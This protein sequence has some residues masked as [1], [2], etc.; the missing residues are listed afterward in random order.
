MRK[1]V[2][3][4]LALAAWT[5][6]VQAQQNTRAQIMADIEKTGGVHYM[7][8]MDQ[9]VPT[10]A[11]KGYQPFY[12]SHVGRHGA[13]FALGGKVYEE[14]LEVWT[15]AH[16]K[17]LL[18]QEGET[19]YEA[20]LQFYPD[21]ARREGNLTRKGQEQHRYI[22][23]SIYNNYPALFK[24][25]THASAVSTVSHRVIVSMF[26]FL[27]E[28]D[29][30]DRDFT[31]DADYGHPYQAFLLPDVIDSQED[32]GGTDAYRQFRR[33]VLDMDA[34]L[35]RWFTQPDAV[36]QDKWGFIYDLHTVVATMDNLDTPASA[37]LYK[38]FTPEERYAIWRV[39]NF[40][41]YEVLGCSPYT[42]NLRAQS[43]MALAQ[44][45][46]A[47]AEEDWDNGVQ[48]RLRF[49][50]DSCLM[51][52]LSLLDVNGMG[53]SLDNPYEVEQYWRTFD[54]PMGCNLQFIFF[55][56]KKHPDI[57]VQ[58]LLNGFE[59]TLPLEMAAP[60]S[61]YRWEDVQGLL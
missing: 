36:I 28:L 9:P 45:I 47:K 15:S 29:N 30:L 37:T 24:G 27:S 53:S 41:E 8:P 51:P 20:Y 60:G 48:L 55:K 3:L 61:F 43:M 18:T 52:L 57:L 26:S 42:E 32:R 4:C 38:L 46:A 58:V 1:L 59:A 19:F 10:A 22:A 14:L 56:S 54:I 25:E 50:H 17:G 7:Y 49:S 6:T 39:Q 2:I 5:G 44:D 12:L 31:F 34:I 11:P 33:K 16:E 40:R 23:R 35:G 21:V 13:R